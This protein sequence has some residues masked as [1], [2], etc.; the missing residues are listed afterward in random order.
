MD[1]V[2]RWRRPTLTWA[3]HED[4][5]SGLAL[6]DEA[7]QLL[8]VNWAF[9]E[10][11]GRSR[12]ELLGACY[13]D[14]LP[15]RDRPEAQVRLAQLLAGEV[16]R[17]HSEER[18]VRPSGEV[19][20]VA[21]TAS[22]ASAGPDVEGAGHP[23]IVRRLADITER[24]RAEVDRDRVFHLA[25]APVAVTGFDGLVKRV[26]PAC[27]AIL[28]W[29]EEELR[30]LR[31]LD[32]V[33]P[34]DRDVLAAAGAKL[35]AGEDV[36]GLEIR[37]LTRDG[38]WRWLLVDA[39]P[40][41]DEQIVYTWNVDITERKWA[42]G[43]LRQR[44]AQLA[45]AQ[46]IARVGS[47]EFNLDEH[48]LQCSDELYRLFGVKQGAS[49][50]KLFARVHVEDRARVR[51]A[52]I[53]ALRSG[54]SF[55]LEFRMAPK[56]GSERIVHVRG[57]V[58]IG[59]SGIIDRL[60]GTLQDVTDWRR[61]EAG[62]AESE[63]RFRRAFEDGPLGVAFID[64]TGQFLRVNSALRQMLG[65]QEDELE[66]R[67]VAEVTC[68]DDADIG[69]DLTRF[70]FD[71]DISGYDIETRF[72]RPD[73]EVV[74]GR[75]RCSAVRDPRGEPLYGLLLVEDITEV[76]EAE[77]ARRELDALKD[78][79]LRVVSHD[80]Q[81][82]LATIAGSAKVL[83]REAPD[84]QRQPLLRIAADADRLRRMAGTFLDMDRLY[85][86]GVRARRR[87]TELS[88]MVHRVIERV[89]RRGHPLLLDIA[90]LVAFV[91][92]DLFEHMVENLLDNACLHTPPGT[93]VSILV[94][95]EAGAVS[96]V[97]EDQGPGVPEDL[98]KSVFELFRTGGASGRRTG[99][100]LWVVARFAE[101]HGGRAWVEDRP[102]GGASFRVLVPPTDN[103]PES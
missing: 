11:V 15:L 68:S 52:A 72:L 96:L 99:V 102:G 16:A 95:G 41:L 77:A 58:A 85:H 42:E 31:Y 5:P 55:A 82:P 10:I 79:F 53:S 74:W 4:V 26:N 92:P 32:I 18:V 27:T 40:V 89:D 29:S 9:C 100:G 94:Q 36:R 69:V 23:T 21:V 46:R 43:R 97:V 20:W 12:E 88:R 91:D 73:G 1:K 70:T 33:D 37:V 39:V 14:M 84:G 61:A 3:N 54:H 66:N 62:L 6:C 51:E 65:A 45:E 60:T 103:P 57:R 98:K 63:E 87:R 19:R 59:P 38:A 93:P 75:V 22:R 25:P 101:L 56:E 13:L 78:G 34:Q 90:P 17:S 86:G 24:R 50:M 83:A 8:E 64:R 80:I 28:G 47:W 48:K 81:G 49:W 2:S 71:S 44:E 7:D 76:R 30:T 35:T 67:T